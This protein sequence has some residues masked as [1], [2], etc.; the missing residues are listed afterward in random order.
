MRNLKPNFKIISQS[1]TQVSWVTE[2]IKAT[3]NFEE[4]IG[5]NSARLVRDILDLK[6]LNRKVKINALNYV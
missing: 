5:I 1:Q 3:R 2:H 4:T 6:S